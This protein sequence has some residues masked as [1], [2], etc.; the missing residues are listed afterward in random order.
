MY[1]YNAMEFR[2][3]MKPR[4]RSLKFHGIIYIYI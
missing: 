3:R 4:G 2:L 1:I